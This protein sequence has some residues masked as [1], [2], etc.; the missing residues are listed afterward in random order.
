MVVIGK[1]EGPTCIVAKILADILSD[2]RGPYVTCD[3]TLAI[4]YKRKQKEEMISITRIRQHEWSMRARS[5]ER[6][7]WRGHKIPL[8]TS[9]T[10]TYL[11]RG[12]YDQGRI[13]FMEKSNSY[14][15]YTYLMA[16]FD[17]IKDSEIISL[18]LLHTHPH[19][20]FP[21]R[22]FSIIE[23]PIYSQRAI[24]KE[25]RQFI[26][27]TFLGHLNVLY[28]DTPLPLDMIAKILSHTFDISLKCAMKMIHLNPARK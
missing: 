26:S 28:K 3:V 18:R 21:I 2:K 19:S 24:I 8:V 22:R 17:S 6:K 20:L 23:K 4:I 9:R 12:R 1:W 10:H 16:V 25:V 27:K 13:R 15:L 11:G 5:V 7:Q 14:E